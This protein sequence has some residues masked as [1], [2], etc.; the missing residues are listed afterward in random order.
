M[1]EWKDKHMFQATY[2]KLL[3]LF[4]NAERADCAKA[5][6]KVLLKKGNYLL[7]NVIIALIA[8]INF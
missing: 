7:H 6:H 5:V 8:K 2:R 4:V 3:E 1:K